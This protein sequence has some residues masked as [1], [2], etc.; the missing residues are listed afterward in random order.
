MLRQDKNSS[1]LRFQASNA[2]PSN[3]CPMVNQSSQA[4]M[5]A[6]S[7]LSCPS[8][9][10]S[11]MP[12]TMLTTTELHLSCQPTTARGL[13]QV[14]W[15]VKSESGRLAI[16][17]RLWK[18]LLK[19]TEEELQTSKLATT[20]LKLC[21]LHTMDLASSGILLPTLESSASLSPPCSSKSSSTQ[22]SLS[23]SPQ[24]PTAKSLTGTASMDR[25]SACLMALSL[26]NLMHL[27][28]CKKVNISSLVEKI[29][30]SDFGTTM[31]VSATTLASDTLA[32]SQR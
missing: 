15:R 8:L 17:P 6:R 19:N 18:H 1:E 31:K 22:T 32:A 12:S 16:R 3:S 29:R 14:V 11:S 28:S 21:L 4:G 30:S 27:L 9:E 24:D 7:D 2:T 13:S 26:E 23:S 5:M 25:R 20:T 10:N